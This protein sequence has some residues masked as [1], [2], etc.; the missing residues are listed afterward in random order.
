M[1]NQYRPMPTSTPAAGKRSGGGCLKGCAIT[2]GVAVGLIVLFVLFVIIFGRTIIGHNLPALEARYP[3][4]GP[5]LDLTGMRAKLI[6]KVD[7][8]RLQRGRLQGANDRELVP[9]DIV[10]YNSPELETYSASSSQVTG[11]QRV[12]ISLDDAHA[13]MLSEMAAQ[14]WELLSDRT[15]DMG[16]Q[17][18][19]KK[20]QRNCQMDLVAFEGYTEIWLRSTVIK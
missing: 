12:G 14:G 11:Y 3:L 18:M 4:L 10:L 8:A 6:P 20:G 7:I 5:A 15:T 16:M 1:Q 19:W 13:H 2:L 9:S 17:L